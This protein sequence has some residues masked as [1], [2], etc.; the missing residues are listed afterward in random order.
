[1][2]M[3]ELGTVYSACE[4][5]A[6]GV[7]GPMAV[8]DIVVQR[9]NQ[10]DQHT[11]DA[12]LDRVL[13]FVSHID[14]DDLEL[15]LL[16]RG[17]GL[18]C[19]V[20]G[21]NRVVVSNQY[22]V[23]SREESESGAVCFRVAVS[24]T[25]PD[26]TATAFKF[27]NN[28]VDLYSQPAPHDIE[29]LVAWAASNLD[30][31]GL[32]GQ[33]QG[34][35]LTLCMK[36]A[37]PVNQIWPGTHMVGT[38]RYSQRIS[39]T[40]TGRTSAQAVLY[41]KNKI[42]TAELLNLAGL[43]GSEHQ[44]VATWE[45]TVKAAEEYGYPVVIKPYDRDNGQ[46]VYAGITTQ[47]DLQH[48]YTE[49]TKIVPQFLVERHFEGVGHRITIVDQNIITVTKKLP[50][51]VTGDGVSTVQQLIDAQQGPSRYI[52]RPEGG[53]PFIL[54]GS[55]V[56]AMTVD[57]EV[58]GM[59]TQQSHTLS[60]VPAE[61]EQLQLRRRNNASAGGVTQAIDKTTVHPDNQELCLRAARIMDLDIAGIDLLIPDIT[62][63]WLATGALI[64][65]VNA[66]PQVGYN[67]GITQIVDHIFQSGVRVPMHM[68]IVESWSQNDL[69]L[70]HEL[71]AITG[72]NAFS[73][74]TGIWINGKCMSRPF[75]NG[76][77]AARAVIFDQQVESAVCIMTKAEVS[78]LG[79]PLD[80]FDQILIENP[81]DVVNWVKPHSVNVKSLKVYR[82]E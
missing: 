39:S 26:A 76:F 81:D 15:Q 73:A 38:G 12:D 14:T 32:P 25:N 45:Q 53:E 33:N 46:G 60:T 11:M 20:Q 80:R 42:A 67:H 69:H 8:L 68:V 19:F 64:C 5:S 37:M 55:A 78:E 63:S 52:K 74:S 40:M 50:A 7:L 31:Y 51:T 35:L 44:K 58:L 23:L 9:P 13:G 6:L 27:A 70:A 4:G 57:D 34:F 56:P 29:P 59:L 17:I 66:V 21:M 1:M 71:A 79:L 61:G 82:N 2:A 54:I 72:S 65:E 16:H 43:P 48:A 28:I 22:Q 47:A 77:T 3:I 41:A 75:A 10:F 62:Q 49:V 18:A 24:V 36:R 30:R